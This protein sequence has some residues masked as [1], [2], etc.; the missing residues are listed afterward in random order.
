APRT[1]VQKSPSSPV[2][3][4]GFGCSPLRRFP[5]CPWPFH[6]ATDDTSRHRERDWNVTRDSPFLVCITSRYN[7]RPLPHRRRD[8]LLADPKRQDAAL[9][10]VEEL[11]TLAAS[12]PDPPPSG[13]NVQPTYLEF[14]AAPLTV[15]P[16]EPLSPL[17]F[18]RLE[19][20]SA[21]SARVSGKNTTI[22]SELTTKRSSIFGAART[23]SSE[24]NAAN[25][26]RVAKDGAKRQVSGYMNV[27]T[28]A[29]LL[30]EDELRFASAP[31][32]RL[33]VRASGLKN[34]L[35]A[36]LDRF[37]VRWDRTP[38]GDHWLTLIGVTRAYKEV[39][40]CGKDKFSTPA[41]SLLVLPQDLRL[42]SAHTKE[43]QL[44]ETMSADEDLAKLRLTP[45][46]PAHRSAAGTASSLFSVSTTLRTRQSTAWSMWTTKTSRAAFALSSRMV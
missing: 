32:F 21:H 5:T 42:T 12:I 38:R 18:S 39:R 3:S 10:Q 26:L 16:C 25:A 28:M 1:A 4:L 17:E 6:G 40:T 8:D 23:V 41:D 33:A 46:N 37:I 29:R 7:L 35:K 27:S 9:G 15:N 45:E 30:L 14:L 34:S 22:P 19:V 36:A 24:T 13:S 44:V 2:R 11:E 43:P 20:T 31:A